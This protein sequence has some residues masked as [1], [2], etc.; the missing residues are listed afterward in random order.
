MKSFHVRLRRGFLQDET[1][2]YLTL[3]IFNVEADSLGEA[4]LYLIEGRPGIWKLDY[5]KENVQNETN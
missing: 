4:V 3:E 2:K 1:L 5:F